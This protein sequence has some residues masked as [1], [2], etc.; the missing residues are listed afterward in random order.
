[1]KSTVKNVTSEPTLNIASP[2][3]RSGWRWWIGCILVVIG[4]CLIGYAGW[5]IF[6]TQYSLTDPNYPLIDISSQQ[7]AATVLTKAS[8][9][10]PTSL[11]IPAQDINLS[12]TPGRILAP[13]QWEISRNGVSYLVGSAL[14]GTKGNIIMYGHNWRGLLRDLPQ[15]TLGEHISINTADGLTHDYVI[16]ETFAVDQKEVS[17]L[18]PTD[19]EVLTLYT[20]SGIINQQRQVLRAVPITSY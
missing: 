19:Y 6:K 5:R 16:T 13:T 3:T 8:P 15:A 20:C 7:H 14:P 2:K 12:V 17:I 4:I 9:S 18:N 1:M 10:Q 11:E